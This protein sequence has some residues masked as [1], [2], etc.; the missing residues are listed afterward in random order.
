ML[1]KNFFKATVCVA[2]LAATSAMAGSF[3]FPQNMKSPHG[4]TI[5]F[6]DTQ[7]CLLPKVPALRFLKLSPTVC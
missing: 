3:P 6:A 7:G 1:M 4:Y 2:A 5:P